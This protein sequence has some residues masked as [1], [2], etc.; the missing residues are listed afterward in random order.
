MKKVS[1]IEL[2][3]PFTPDV[4]G[5]VYALV[6]VEEGHT[7]YGM[8]RLLPDK[9]AAQCA[10]AV[11]SM[12]TELR[13]VSKDPTKDLV[14]VHSDDDKSF[15]GELRT[16]LASEGIRQTDTGGYRPT[17]NSRVERRIRMINEAFRAS[18][19]VA[20]GGLT[21]YESLWGPGL[22]QAMHSSNCSVWM[23]GRCPYRTTCDW[24]GV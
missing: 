20:T 1:G 17:N 8:I 5:N 4:D 9:T 22:V 7:D 16:W 10:E 19:L 3:G 14:R 15:K 24:Q 11:A 12:R 13:T 2:Y 18:L 23:D 6:G 21:I